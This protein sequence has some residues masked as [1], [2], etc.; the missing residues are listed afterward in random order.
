LANRS[1]LLQLQVK[2][3]MQWAMV[4]AVITYQRVESGNALWLCRAIEV[5]AAIGRT[6]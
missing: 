5:S 3:A 1:Y 2:V 4:E 6:N